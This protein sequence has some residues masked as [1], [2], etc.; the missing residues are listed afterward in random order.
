MFCANEA[1]KNITTNG[2][3]ILLV[4]H[5]GPDGDAL[6]SVFA[7]AHALAQAGKSP[8]IYL[9]VYNEKYD[10]VEGKSFIC[11]DLS[12]HQWDVL[13]AVD[14]G[15]FNRVFVPQEVFE[16][17]GI[18]VNIDHHV[19]SDNF[20][21]HNY[22]EP[23]AA[24]ACELVYDIIPVD[25]LSKNV[26]DALYLGIVTDTG[27][28]KYSSTSPRTMEIAAE[29]MRAGADFTRIQQAVLHNRSKAEVTIFM[30]A[31]GNLK[32]TDCGIAY[33]SL[34]LNEMYEAKARRFHLEGIVEYLLNIEDVRASVFFCERENRRVKASFRSHGVDVRQVAAQFGGGG[35]NFAAATDFESDFDE[36]VENVLNALRKAVRD[37]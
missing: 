4:T 26:A 9:D 7:L 19:N 32:F 12:E 14:C 3:N 10:V 17:A 35:H 8:R 28:F 11:A 16:G 36:G 34:T 13:V 27:A 31:L 22:V 21:T 18:T 15:D 25:R 6:G 37:V 24:A 1:W 30:R 2:N 5:I 23:T 20:A 29:L 33:T